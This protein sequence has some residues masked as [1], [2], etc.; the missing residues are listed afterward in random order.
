MKITYEHYSYITLKIDVNGL[1]K[2]IEFFNLLNITEF[3]IVPTEYYNLV[4]C[5]YSTTSTNDDCTV[6]DTDPRPLYRT[7]WIIF[8]QILVVARYINLVDSLNDMNE[9]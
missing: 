1:E 5:Q 8:E 3:V 7:Q 9:I 2:F 6:Q 4:E